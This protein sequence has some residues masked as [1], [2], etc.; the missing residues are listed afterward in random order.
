[1][2]NE[3]VEVTSHSKLMSKNEIVSLA[4]TFV[5]LGVNKIR[6][7]GGEPLIRKDVAEI[8]EELSLL[9]VNLTMTTNG[10]LI[11]KYID[12]LKKANVQSINVSLDTLNADTFLLLT[13]RNHFDQVKSNIELLLQHNFSVKVNVVAMKGINDHE[14]NSFVV[15]TKNQPIHVRFIEFMPFTA[16]QWHHEKVISYKEIL[17]IISE[18]FD[19]IKLIDDKND[20][21]KKYKV[22]GHQGTFA[23]ISTMTA[24]FCS[25]CNRIRLTADGK[26]KNCLFSKTETDLLTALRKNENIV[27]LIHGN[28]LNKEKELGGQL[29]S[30]FTKVDASILENR[31]MISIGG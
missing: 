25:S 26:L 19:F 6:L 23:I 17:N 8:I 16:N 9:N 30:D 12:V 14:I 28:F 3:E 11:H 29:L 7:T 5:K 13:K 4:K 31:S 27:A 24:P 1:M 18:E 20:T 10:L 15:W 2:P 21:T 22:V